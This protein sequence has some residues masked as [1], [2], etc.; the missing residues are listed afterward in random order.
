[1][2]YVYRALDQEGNRLD[3]CL[4]EICDLA[5]ACS[6]FRSARVISK[7]SPLPMTSDL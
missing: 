7:R 6:F 4:S 2:G 3:G 1:M 5:A